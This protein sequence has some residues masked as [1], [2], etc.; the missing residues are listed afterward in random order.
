M[1]LHWFAKVSL[2]RIYLTGCLLK[3]PL[4]ASELVGAEIPCLRVR[5]LLSSHL[6]ASVELGKRE[7]PLRWRGR[8]D[9]HD[10][11]M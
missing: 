5:W 1:G 11:F 8:C 6:S 3:N 9:D 2:R 10:K 7:W 4:W